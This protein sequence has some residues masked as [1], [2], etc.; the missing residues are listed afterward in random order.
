M[1]ELECNR[2]I[3]SENNTKDISTNENQLNIPATT[4][5]SK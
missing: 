1:R 2:Q 5:P 3:N 4:K